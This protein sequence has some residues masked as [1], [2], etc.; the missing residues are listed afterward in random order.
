MKKMLL[1]M[2]VMACASTS[3]AKDIEGAFGFKF[4]EKISLPQAGYVLDIHQNIIGSNVWSVTVNTGVTEPFDK[5]I[6]TVVPDTLEISGIS[7]I[8][9][10]I[11]AQECIHLMSVYRRAIYDKYDKLIYKDQKSDE[12]SARVTYQED[13]HKGKSIDVFC[14]WKENG[15]MGKGDFVIGYYDMFMARK[16]LDKDIE[17]IDT[18]LL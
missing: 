9:E 11:D 1:F 4:G 7:A 3:G 18:S 13:K 6:L 8:K 15:M 16:E 10:N 17:K 5:Y 14:V 2:A 12:I